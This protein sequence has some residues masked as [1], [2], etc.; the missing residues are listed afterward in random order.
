ME[1]AYEKENCQHDSDCDCH[2]AGGMLLGPSS[3]S[4]DSSSWA[5]WPANKHHAKTAGDR[6]SGGCICRR[7]SH[8]SDDPRKEEYKGL[9][10]G[11]CRHCHSDTELALQP[12]TLGCC[13]SLR[14]RESRPPDDLR[15]SGGRAV[16]R[17]SPQLCFSGS[18]VLR[19]RWYCSIWYTQ[20]PLSRK[21]IPVSRRAV[22]NAHQSPSPS[23]REF[24]SHHPGR[25]TRLQGI[26]RTLFLPGSMS[27]PAF[28]ARQM[29]R[30][31]R[32]KRTRPTSA[33]PS[34]RQ[35]KCA[36]SRRGTLSFPR[37]NPA[38]V[39]HTITLRSSPQG[40]E[41]QQTHPVISTQDLPKPRKKKNLSNFIEIYQNK[42]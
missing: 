23:K 41:K 37:R 24:A 10:P 15:P 8:A 27:C 6:R 35:K 5:G 39:Y 20:T 19:F 9:C 31:A 42:W 33:S 17:R 38:S 4:C 34:A 28:M 11:A 12:V 18:L 25:E 1:A 32:A 3:R 30:C 13:M 36:A 14:Q 7:F 16:Q 22:R 21:K 2:W 26:R 29:R 40:E